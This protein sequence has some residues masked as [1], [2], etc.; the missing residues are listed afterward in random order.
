MKLCTFKRSVSGTIVCRRFQYPEKV[1]NIVSTAIVRSMCEPEV[2]YF[3]FYDLTMISFY[4]NLATTQLTV[5]LC[6]FRENGKRHIFY[7]IEPK[8]GRK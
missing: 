6:D 5:E 3:E 2:E 8:Y 4:L 7:C 1:F